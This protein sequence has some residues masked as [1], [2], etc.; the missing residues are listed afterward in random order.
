MTAHGAGDGAARPPDPADSEPGVIDFVDMDAPIRLSDYALEDYATLIVFW[1]LAIVV[2][3]QFFTRYVLNNP[4]AWTEEIARYLL[5]GVAFLGSAMA[6]RRNTHIMVEFFYRFL[7]VSFASGLSTLVDI[8]RILFFAATATITF[9]LARMTTTP[10]VSVP[11]PKSVIYYTVFA[12]LVIMT[13]RAVQ[14]AVRHW[15]QGY[16][17]LTHPLVHKPVD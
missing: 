8:I 3:T 2:F 7:P 4:I 1:F 6:V 11:I 13:G 15:R 9:G 5:I 10:M 16:S 14:V 12:G 17:S